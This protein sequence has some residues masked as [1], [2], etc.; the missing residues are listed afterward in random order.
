M[1]QYLA[2]SNDYCSHC[3]ARTKQIWVEGLP[4]KGCAVECG[5]VHWN[6]PTPVVAVVVETPQ[7]VV[8]A[9]NVAWPENVFSIITGFL[10][11][12]ELPEECAVRETREEL[13][14]K[15]YAPKF[16]G[17]YMFKAKNQLIIGYSVKAEGDVVLNH[18]LDDYKIIPSD[19]LQGWPGQTGQTVSD[20]VHLNRFL[21]RNV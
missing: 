16:I 19:K 15:A 9:H 3:G 2:P 17:H 1:T 21:K 13:G 6:N 18:E 7:G 10:D 12:H 4:F 8:L 11:A 14:L 20:W 5:F